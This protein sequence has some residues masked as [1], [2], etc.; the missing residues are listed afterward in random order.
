MTAVARFKQSDVTRALKG[1]VGAGLKPAKAI[2]DVN[3]NIV[4]SFGN[5]TQPGGRSSWDDL[6]DHR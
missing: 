4:L 2:I 3:G 5:D 1:A 6:L